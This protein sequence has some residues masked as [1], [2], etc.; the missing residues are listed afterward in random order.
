MQPRARDYFRDLGVRAD[1]A[2]DGRSMK[3]QM[4]VA[5]RSGTAYAV[6]GYE[7]KIAAGEA[8]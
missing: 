2:S 4:K 7:D 5:D 6:I 3:A 1:R 8:T